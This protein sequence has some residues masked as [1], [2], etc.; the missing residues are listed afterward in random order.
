[1]P[2]WWFY[3]NVDHGQ[4]IC[5]GSVTD[6]FVQGVNYTPALIS[7]MNAKGFAPTQIGEPNPSGVTASSTIPSS[8]PGSGSTSTSTSGSGGTTGGAGNGGG[9][10]G[11]GTSSNGS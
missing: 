1:M 8:Y 9:S 3:Q 2:L 4:P 6:F 10:T 5:G 7:A 11:G